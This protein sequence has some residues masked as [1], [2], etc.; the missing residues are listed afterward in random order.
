MYVR[1][2]MGVAVVAALISAT[3]F[4][5]PQGRTDGP[6]GSEYGTGGYDDPG[7]GPFSLQL[8]WGAAVQSRGPLG[9]SPEGPP[10]VLGATGSFWG[11]ERFVLDATVAYLFSNNQLDV[12]VGPRFRTG[13]FPVSAS[14][15]LQ[16]GALIRNSGDVYFGLSPTLSADMLLKDHIVLGLGYALDIPIGGPDLSHRIFMNVGYRF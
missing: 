1:R 4:A 16:A 5:Q 7:S 9:G 14:A 2:E 12:L 13:T 3:A 11:D 6:E 10:M 8:H 15:G